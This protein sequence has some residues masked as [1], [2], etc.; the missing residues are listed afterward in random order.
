MGPK[1]GTCILAL[2]PNSP[3]EVA[4]AAVGSL[5]EVSHRHHTHKRSLFPFYVVPESNSGYE[6]LKLAFGL[7]EFDVIAINARRSWWRALPKDGSGIQESDVTEE[8][9]ERWVD[10]IRLGEGA[11]QKL[12]EGLVP[13]E[14][15]VEEADEEPV[16][17]EETVVVEPV[18]EVKIEVEEVKEDVHD[19]L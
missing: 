14:P 10:S 1:T 12:P 7:G 18:E 15:V 6:K 8:A 16:A 13:E 9:I 17:A 5:S 11:K 4:A 19:E 3:N 2:L